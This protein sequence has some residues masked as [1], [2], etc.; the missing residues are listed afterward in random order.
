MGGGQISEETRRKLSEANKGERNPNYGKHLTEETRRKISEAK[1]GKHRT[2]TEETRRKLSEA[3]NKKVECI[4]TN[5]IYSSLA[6]AA[7]KTNTRHISEV[8]NGRRKTAGGYHWRY[9]E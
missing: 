3:H 7:T 8:C 4:E 2:L 5:K 6:E 1:K 9:I